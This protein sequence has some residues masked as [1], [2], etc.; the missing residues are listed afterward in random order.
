MSWDLYLVRPKDKD[1][2]CPT[3][4]HDPSADEDDRIDI[5]NYTHNTNDMLRVVW[6]RDPNIPIGISVAEA[7]LFKRQRDC[8]YLFQDK[9]ASEI[10][11]EVERAINEMTE[12][13][14]HFCGLQPD[15]GWGSLDGLRQF[16]KHIASALRAHPDWTMDV[17]G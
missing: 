8:W 10:L 16:L 4:G 17:S 12:Q 1:T 2:K 14:G 11:P 6:G 13:P 5:G 7:V 3:C 15:N 9:K